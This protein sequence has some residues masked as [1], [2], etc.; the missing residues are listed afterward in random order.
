VISRLEYHLPWEFQGGAAFVRPRV[1]L[2]VDIQPY[3]SI[4]AYA[5]LASMSPC[6]CTPMLA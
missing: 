6:G 3:T 2:E 4:D 5:L 1:E